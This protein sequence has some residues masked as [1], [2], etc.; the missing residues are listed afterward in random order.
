MKK[1]T[2]NLADLYEAVRR[3]PSLPDEA[4]PFGFAQRVVAQW[5]EIQNQDP[6]Y[7]IFS[8]LASPALVCSWAIAGMALLYTWQAG[9]ISPANS[10]PWGS[11]YDSYYAEEGDDAVWPPAN[12]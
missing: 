5:R 3:N 9:S 6:V 2:K 7:S 1:P 11:A 12:G 10:S 8:R 4:A